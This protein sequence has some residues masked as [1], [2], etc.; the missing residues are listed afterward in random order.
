MPTRQ[1]PPDN[2]APHQQ[3]AIDT[4]NTLQQ[5]LWDSPWQVAKT[6]ESVKR[7]LKRYEEARGGGQ[8]HLRECRKQFGKNHRTDAGIR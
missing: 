3:D 5:E 6:R 8:A 7:T 4:L 1:P 2:L